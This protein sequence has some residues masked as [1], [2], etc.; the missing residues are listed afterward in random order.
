M[1][2]K[3]L[4]M[5][6]VR[7]LALST[8]AIADHTGNYGMN[9][10]GTQPISTAYVTWPLDMYLAISDPGDGGFVS[11]Y[12]G[13]NRIYGDPTHYACMT[14]AIINNADPNFIPWATDGIPVRRLTMMSM[15]NQWSTLGSKIYEGTATWTNRQTGAQ[16]V[17]GPLNDTIQIIPPDG[18][19]TVLPNLGIAQQQQDG[20]WE[21]DMQFGFRLDSTPQLCDLSCGAVTIT[22]HGNIMPAVV[23][24][25][26]ATMPT[27]IS[28]A[29]LITYQPNDVIASMALTITISIFST[30][31]LADHDTS[32]N[33]TINMVRTSGGYT[34]SQQ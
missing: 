30:D 17:F 3:I 27:T 14:T 1:K 5:N 33:I 16:T 15:Q 12:D 28:N 20:S 10:F 4:A 23:Q 2:R 19:S 26:Y 31:D 11:A 21:A 29:E 34:L 8:A 18:G 9:W 22:W 24:G 32:F 25:R 13:W 6:L 7:L